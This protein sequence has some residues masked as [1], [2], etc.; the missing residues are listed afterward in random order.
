MKR[1]V[2]LDD[3]LK[4]GNHVLHRQAPL[5]FLKLCENVVLHVPS[6]LQHSHIGHS[7][8]TWGY[9]PTGSGPANLL[10]EWC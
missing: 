7:P 8:A 3:S 9:I 10:S 1:C 2:S 5:M 6:I 4:V